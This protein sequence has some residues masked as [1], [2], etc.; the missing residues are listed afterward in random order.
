MILYFLLLLCI[1]LVIFFIYF[2]LLSGLFS[3]LKEKKYFKFSV[4][5]IIL[6]FILSATFIPGIDN[7]LNKPDNI[8]KE[9]FVFAF[10]F[11]IPVCLNLF[12]LSEKGKNTFVYNYIIKNKI[13][14]FVIL[15]SSLSIIFLLAKTLRNLI[16][17][18]K[19]NINRFILIVLLIFLKGHILEVLYIN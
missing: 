17:F 12:L 3:N 18:L 10:S 4:Y 15:I 11:L 5:L 8:K 9:L 1:F 2:F 14:I 6:I 13:F 16:K 7:I 19:R